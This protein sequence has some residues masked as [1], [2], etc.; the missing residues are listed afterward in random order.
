MSGFFKSTKVN[1]KWAKTPFTYKILFCSEGIWRKIFLYRKNSI[2][3]TS[4]KFMYNRSSV[5]PKIFLNYIVNIHTGKIWKQRLINKWM[6][7]YKFG[8]FTWNKRVATFK[9]K[10]AKKKKH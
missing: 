1:K 3:K 8:E 4:E 10:Q 7:G 6:V 9:A 5:I 2:F